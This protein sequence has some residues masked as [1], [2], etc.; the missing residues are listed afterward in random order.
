M[1]DVIDRRELKR[2]M[3]IELRQEAKQDKA[4]QRAEFDFERD[5]GARE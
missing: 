4:D 2:D 3:D 5:C 1:D